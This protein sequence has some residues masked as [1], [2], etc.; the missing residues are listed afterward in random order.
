M[1]RPKRPRGLCIWIDPHGP[2]VTC[3]RV[4]R[5]RVV[6]DYR[7]AGGRRRVPSFGP[8]ED[9][10]SWEKARAAKRRLRYMDDEDTETTFGDAWD[11]WL[12]EVKLEVD[13]TTHERYEDSGRLY[14]LPAFKGVRLVKIR[15]RRIKGLILEMLAQRKPSK[16]DPGKVVPRY[17][18]VTIRKRV[19]GVLANFLQW[20]VDEEMILNNPAR[21]LSRRLFR[22]K[23]GEDVATVRRSMSTEQM[24]KWTVATETLVDGRT[25][26]GLMLMLD[27]ALR[28]GEMLG[29]RLEDFD[30]EGN[31][32]HVVRQVRSSRTAAIVAPPKSK[33]GVRDIEMSARIKEHA[34][35]EIRF[36]A[37]KALKFGRKPSPW[38]GW[39]FF[40]EPSRSQARNA[41]KHYQR[42]MKRLC[43]AAGIARFTPHGLRHTWGTIQ[44]E[45]GAGQKALQ[46]WYGHAS[47]A[48]TSEY[49]QHARPRLRPDADQ[50]PAGP[51]LM[52]HLAEERR[53]RVAAFESAGTT[54]R[55]R[56]T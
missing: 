55:R 53:P 2:A 36:R 28:I 11:M 30:F 14:L 35:A 24:V 23:K 7:D 46:S 17:S 21:E 25:F 4:R 10:E 45:H 5:G 27:G 56:E 8:K 15:R 31:V 37:E 44:A 20:A 29:L 32:I 1:L 26:L 18:P 54:P 39:Q 3:I 47:A 34:Q 52:E 22:R 50:E 42:A 49:T 16:I 43:A 38:I 13:D 33:S 48:Q 6:L 51:D 41:R 9:D 12:E 19:L 40:E